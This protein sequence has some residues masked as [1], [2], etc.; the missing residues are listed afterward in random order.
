[1]ECNLSFP[2]EPSLRRVESP[3]LQPPKQDLVTVGELRQTPHRLCPGSFVDLTIKFYPG[4]P[5]A[6]TFYYH[7]ATGIPST[8]RWAIVGAE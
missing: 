2:S 4:N 6:V 7:V 3:L 1:M 8:F 5:F